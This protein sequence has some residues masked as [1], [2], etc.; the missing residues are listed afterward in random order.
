M[1]TTMPLVPSTPPIRSAALEGSPPPQACL[2]R[3]EDL[4]NSPCGLIVKPDDEYACGHFFALGVDGHGADMRIVR[5]VSDRRP[6]RHLESRPRI[7]PGT[8]RVA[9]VLPAWNERT[10]WAPAS[11]R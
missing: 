2:S 1:S 9:F 10:C 3:D 4:P 6:A 5:P 7:G 8:P 11:M